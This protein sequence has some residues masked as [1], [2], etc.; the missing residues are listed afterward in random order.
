MPGLTRHLI[1]ELRSNNFLEIA[2]QA[3][4]D[5]WDCGFN[6]RND[7]WV[8]KAPGLNVHNLHPHG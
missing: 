2:G 8:L 6:V 1:I 4:N 7:G 3:R 5:R